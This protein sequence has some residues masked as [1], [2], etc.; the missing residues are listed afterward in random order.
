MFS[1]LFFYFLFNCF[2]ICFSF[3]KVTNNWI[4]ICYL[5]IRYFILYL[6]KYNDPDLISVLS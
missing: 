2:I 3:T 1:I 4:P 5:F 6:V